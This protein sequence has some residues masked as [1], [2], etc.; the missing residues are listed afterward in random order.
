MQTLIIFLTGIFGLIIGSFLNVII[1]R[2]NTGK[3]IGGRS[4]CLSCRKT[5][6]WYELIPLVSFLVQHGKC[7]KCRSHISWQYPIIELVTAIAFA[8][9]ALRIDVLNY[10][11][12]FILWLGIVATSVVISAYDFHH[13]TI[14]TIPLGFLVFLSIALGGHIGA[15]L[16]VALPFFLL[17]LV[18]NG[19]WIGFGDIELM[20]CTGVLL[21]T[22]SGY[23]SAFVSFWLATLLMIPW[24]LYH[25]VTHKKFSH[26]IPFGP[27]LLIGIFL[28]GVCGLDILNVIIRVIY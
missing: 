5:L 3:G 12:T 14:P 26:E 25:K 13:K 16:L 7:R 15:G 18:S 17:W 23:S 10:P 1:Y 24:Y 28:V 8:L 11:V 4:H 21:G 22:V 9:V 20:A 27:F 19:R 6:V 2:L